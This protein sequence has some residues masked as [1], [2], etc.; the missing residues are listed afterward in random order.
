MGNKILFVIASGSGGHILPSI[1]LAKKWKLKEHGKVIFFTGNK[2]ID[3]KILEDS[4][5]IDKKIYLKLD[6][7]PGKKILLYPVFFTQLFICLI[8]SIY[9]SYKYKPNKII[10]TG[11]YLAIPVC[12]AGKL[13]RSFIELYELNVVPGR[14][15]VFLSFIAN[16]I[17]IVFKDSKKH[18]KKHSRKLVLTNYPLRYSD[19][20]KIFN[21]KDLI[22]KIN[23]EYFFRNHNS[24][25]NTLLFSENKK[26]I[27]LLGGSQGSIFLNNYFKNWLIENKDITKK[28]QI[29]HQTGHNDKTNLI[30][31]YKN[32]NIP[33]IIF[34]YQQNLKN[35]YLLADEVVTRAGAG[36]LFELEFF[37][38]KSK[39]FPLIT[40]TTSH[41]VD[42]AK[43]ME[44]RNEGLFEIKH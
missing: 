2:K 43:I 20:D 35:Y 37:K 25:K 22:E 7:F 41:Q 6:S 13:F 36:T 4:N 44:K 18:L 21:K 12:F 40:T 19:Q 30:S 23:K 31:F 34:S 11:G 39:I 29:I 16:K 17:S 8:K 33:A 26:T 10:T 32:L 5:V 14:T 15:I 28:I 24:E 1:V 38:K 3:Q 42:N 27:F 9:Y